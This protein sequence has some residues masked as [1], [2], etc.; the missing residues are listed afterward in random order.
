MASSSETGHAKNIANL[1]LLNTNIV[2]LG[3]TYNPSNPKLFILKL[4]TTYD[5]GFTEQE[6]VNKL[7]APYTVAV[8]EREIVFKPLNRDLTKLRKAY[9]ATDGVTIVQLQDFMTII[10]KLK[11]IKKSKDKAVK[12]INFLN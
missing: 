2:A 6:S 4:Q 5:T 8:D 11:G 9:K 7:V 12:V 3:P 10:R 1:N